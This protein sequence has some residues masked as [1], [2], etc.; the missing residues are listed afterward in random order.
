VRG[1]V[2]VGANL[3]RVLVAKLTMPIPAAAELRDDTVVG[4]SLTDQGIAAGGNGVV[5]APSAQLARGRVDR[6]NAE[7]A[8]G[9]VVCGKQ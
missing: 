4:K 5:D 2:K 9:A 8:V 7:K 3:R 6:R 1:A